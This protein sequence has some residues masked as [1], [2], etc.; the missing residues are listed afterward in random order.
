MA[1]D[2][3]DIDNLPEV[4]CD[5]SCDWFEHDLLLMNMH[6]SPAQRLKMLGNLFQFS[7]LETLFLQ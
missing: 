6:G 5:K 2:L 4:D 3:T 7:R 1:R